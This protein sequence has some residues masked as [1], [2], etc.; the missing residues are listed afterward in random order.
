MATD[1]EQPKKPR[2]KRVNKYKRRCDRGSAKKDTAKYDEANSAKLALSMRR[3]GLT[4][5]QIADDFTNTKLGPTT[6][7]GVRKMIYRHISEIPRD[8]AQ[9]VL[10]LELE[11]LDRRIRRAIAKRDRFDERQRIITQTLA[12]PRTTAAEKIALIEESRRLDDSDTRADHSE[13]AVA[14]LRISLFG[15]ASPTRTEVTGANGAP[16]ALSAISASPAEAARLVRE[17][18]GEDAAMRSPNANIVRE[19]FAGDPNGSVSESAPP[20]TDGDRA[21]A[22]APTVPGAAPTK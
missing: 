18:F 22:P 6:R 17:A 19:A 4:L 21:D 16:L 8:E 12:L 9:D 11:R 15:L 14:T 7:G 2:K 3:D 13:Q 5:Q 1:E 10:A 20:R